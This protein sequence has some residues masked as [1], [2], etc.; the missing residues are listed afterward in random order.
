VNP[1]VPLLCF[2]Q[3]TLDRSGTGKNPALHVLKLIIGSI[4]DGAA[5]NADCDTYR[6]T[7]ELNCKT[8]CN[9]DM[10]PTRAG[11]RGSLGSFMKLDEMRSLRRDA[12]PIV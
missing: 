2:S 9:H 4:E 5:R 1:I 11:K 8:L 3:S 10:T 12:R 7:L 6:A